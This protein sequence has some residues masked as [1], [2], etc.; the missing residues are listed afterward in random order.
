MYLLVS[1]HIDYSLLLTIKVVLFCDC[2]RVTTGAATGQKYNLHTLISFSFSLSLRLFIFL[3][4]KRKSLLLLFVLLFVVFLHL[5]CVA[6][7]DEIG[8]QRLGESRRRVP[9]KCYLVLLLV[10]QFFSL[11]LS[12]S[13]SLVGWFPGYHQEGERRVHSVWRMWRVGI[14]RS[15][16]SGEEERKS[17]LTQLPPPQ[18]TTSNSCTLSVCVYIICSLRGVVGCTIPL[19]SL[20]FLFFFFIRDEREEGIRAIYFHFDLCQV[21]L[22]C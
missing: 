16:E 6:A 1:N 4:Q 2:N 19:F 11:F 21:L 7:P 14:D 13:L 10:S 20:F 5:F 9:G 15:V 22:H 17:R 18:S 3:Y 8:S 12:L